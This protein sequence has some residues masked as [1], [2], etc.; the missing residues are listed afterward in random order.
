M[1]L[2]R[3]TPHLGEMPSSQGTSGTRWLCEIAG[4]GVLYAQDVASKRGI[5]IAD[6]LFH[7]FLTMPDLIPL[8]VEPSL[9]AIGFGPSEQLFRSGS[10][11]HLGH[12]ESGRR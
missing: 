3:V 9:V 12:R 11:T 10:S 5:L 7:V 2:Y 6:G 8:F 4:T 1:A